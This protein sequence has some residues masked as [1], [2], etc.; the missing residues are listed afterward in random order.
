MM[1][2]QHYAARNGHADVCELLLRNG[3]QVNTVTRTGH[4][5][6]LHRA[7][8]CGHCGV[9]QLLLKFGALTLLCD[10]DGKTALHKVNS[11]NSLRYPVCTSAVCTLLVCI[12]FL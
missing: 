7:A 3:A 8:Y 9:I 12:T 5:S 6:A 10:A 4:V 1:L 2:V 11:H